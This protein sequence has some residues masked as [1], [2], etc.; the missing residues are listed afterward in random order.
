M[1]CLY[2]AENVRSDK[3]IISIFTDNNIVTQICFECFDLIRILNIKY[4]RE[5]NQVIIIL[6][7]SYSDFFFRGHNQYIFSVYITGHDALV[8]SRDHV[9]YRGE[10]CERQEGVTKFK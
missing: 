5:M 4:T 9:I 1:R 7:C 2:L 3:V 10:N 8:R 6:C